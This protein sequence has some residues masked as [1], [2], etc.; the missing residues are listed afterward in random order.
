M[1][2][3]TNSQDIF[4]FHQGT[5]YQAYNLM[6][7]H[8]VKTMGVNAWRFRCYAPNAVSVSVVGDFN[9]WLCGINPMTK[10][11]QGI[12]ECVVPSLKP[13]DNYKFALEIGDGTVL[14]KAD[15]YALH[16][17]TPPGTASKLYDI[18]AFEWTDDKWLERR[19]RMNPYSSPMNIYEMHLGSWKKHSDGNPYTYLE[20]ADELVPYLKEMSYTHVEL[21]PITEYPFDGSWGYQVSGMFAPTSRF[22]TPSDFQVFVNRLHENGIGVILDWVAA[23]FPKDAFGLYRFDGT[24]LYEYEDDNK[25]EH[26]EWGTVVYDYN[27]NEVRSFLISSAMFWLK[28]YHIDGLRLDA[29]ASMLYLDYARKDGEWSPNS[30]GGNINLEAVAFLRDLNSAVMTEVPGVITIA[31]ESTSFEGVTR[32]TYQGGLGFCFKW[33][34]GWMNDTLDYLKNDPLFRQYNHERLTFP[35]AYAYAENYILPLSHDEV[36][37]GKASLLNKQAGYY[38]DK[39]AALKCTIGYMMSFVGKK[40]IFMGNEFAQVIEWNYERELDWFLLQY[41]IHDDHLRFVRDLNA[42]YLNNPALYE[43]DT[44]IRGFEWLVV[45]DKQQNIIVYRRIASNGDY[46]ICVM[47]FS[48][49]E[50]GD[51][52]FGVPNAGSYKLDLCSFDAKYGG[53]GASVKTFQAQKGEMHGREQYISIC[54]PANSVQF[55]SKK[56][57]TKSVTKK[58]ADVKTKKTSIGGK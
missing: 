32:P 58:N 20:L 12:W 54:V 15:P 38:V 37:H 24:Y 14:F 3:N 53:Q 5:N 49:I 36:V 45:D 23:H 44:S 28:E 40:L 51:Y 57:T 35:F 26:K 46:I 18:S 22:G 16:T 30:E 43:L 8:A 34:M 42:Y 10:V 31:E 7:P 1:Q 13:Y 21:M 56:N 50:R 2:K 9:D 41:P 6:S 29:V 25:R 11:S 19:A 55:I 47:N 48:P 17:E 4:L 33:N 27:K 39:F 52:R